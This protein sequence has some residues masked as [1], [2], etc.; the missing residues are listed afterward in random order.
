[1]QV[2]CSPRSTDADSVRGLWSRPSVSCGLFGIAWFQVS[3]ASD[4]SSPPCLHHLTGVDLISI[5]LG[6]SFCWC[7][8]AFDHRPKFL[9]TL[10]YKTSLGHQALYSWLLAALWVPREDVCS[11]FFLALPYQTAAEHWRF[12]SGTV[13]F[14]KAVIKFPE[15]NSCLLLLR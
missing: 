8:Q 14:S 12:L 10:R 11:S 1:M 7:P 2:F 5:L 4:Q 9:L 15:L 6:T 3:W 13:S